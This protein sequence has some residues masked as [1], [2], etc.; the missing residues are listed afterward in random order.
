MAARTRWWR[1]RRIRAAWIR[2]PGA[3]ETVRRFTW[4]VTPN[5]TPGAQKGAAS[6]GPVSRL[7]V[8]VDA[9][10]HTVLG[11]ER[12]RCAPECRDRPHPRRV[13]G[14]TACWTRLAGSSTSGLIAD[15]RIVRTALSPPGEHPAGHGQA[16]LDAGVYFIGIPPG[17]GAAEIAPGIHGVWNRKAGAAPACCRRHPSRSSSI[18]ARFVTSWWEPARLPRNPSP[19][20]PNA[21]S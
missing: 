17:P 6:P 14:A 8:R 18:R 11:E 5:A 3:T 7:E 1:L 15:P 16:L 12:A 21:C 13:N 19:C 2:A 9:N 20:R 4:Q 10:G